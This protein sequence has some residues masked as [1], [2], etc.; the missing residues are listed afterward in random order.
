MA[1]GG[2]RIAPSGAALT[3]LAGATAAAAA[4]I[5]VA[6]L[7]VD[8]LL[9]PRLDVLR[10]HPEDYAQGRYGLLVNAAYLALAIALVL[11]TL[12]LLAGWRW[13]G[14]AGALLL[15]P[16]VLCAALAVDPPNV[17]RSGDW[18]SLAVLGLALGPL[19]VSATLGGLFGARKR[20]ALV[21]AALVLGAFVALMAAPEGVS[22]VV[23]RVFDVLAGAWVALAGL[24]I[25]SRR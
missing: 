13:R 20:T 15:P 5:Y 6:I 2:S 12:L 1:L 4:G 18:I 23:N 21:L 25:G 11:V 7:V 9:N 10:V 3:G 19:A 22:G 17:A 16:A 24:A 8:P 14:A